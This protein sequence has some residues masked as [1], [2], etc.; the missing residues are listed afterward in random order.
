MPDRITL[1]QVR[2][3]ARLAHLGLSDAQVGAIAFDLNSILDHMDA[4]SRVDTSGVA[5]YTAGDAAMP[6]RADHGDPVPLAARPETFAP[7]MRDG[8]FVVPRLAT[9]EDAEP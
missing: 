8:F 3:I 5:E 1:E 6:L 4:L 9:H 7:A 2:H